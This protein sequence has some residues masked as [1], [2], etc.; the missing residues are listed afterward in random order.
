MPLMVVSATDAFKR[1][2]HKD[3]RW[4]RSAE[5][6]AERLIPLAQPRFWP[7]FHINRSELIFTIGSCF[8]RNIEQQLITEGYKVAASSFEIPLD[9]RFKADPDALTNRYVVTSIASELQWGFGHGK[10]Y[11]MRNLVYLGDDDWF[12]PHLHPLVAP[13]PLKTVMERREAIGRYMAMAK[14]A[15]VFIMTLGLAEAWYDTQS[16]LY[17]NAVPPTRAREAFPDRFE[18]H[19]LDYG[20]ILDRLEL[21]HALLARYGRPDFRM[22]VT[23]S[24]VAMN[25]TFTGGDV[26]VANSYS[27]AVQRAAVEA[28]V[29]GHDNVDYFPSFESVMLSDRRRAWR[30]DQAHASDEIVRLNVLRMV[31]AYAD[32]EETTDDLQAARATR[33]FAMVQTAR[34]AAGLDAPDEAIAAYH[35]AIE[36]APGEALILLE[37]GRFLYE[38]RQNQEA[39]EMIEASTRCGSGSYGGFYYL[40]Q[41]YYASRRMDEAYE[42]ATK[43]RELQ[44]TRPGVIDLSANIALKLGRLEEAM[45]LAKTHLQLD[46]S[47]LPSRE[48]LEQ[49]VDQMKAQRANAAAGRGEG[50]KRLLD[51][52]GAGRRKRIRG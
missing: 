42:A 3:S 22:L 16:G 12:D 51:Q 47:S 9:L 35:A 10:P 17:L 4:P 36:A 2:R 1:V 41:V 27:K 21:I 5:A 18:F 43:A 31:E 24:P 45:D 15:R 39:A 52:A 29:R 44:P 23:V 34:D 20:Q 50:V 8:A 49:L 25:T 6:Q 28:F 48:R 13:A 40:A 33:A 30:E 32:P 14:E 19:L 7:S 11:K 26:L 37:F 38:Q 46:P